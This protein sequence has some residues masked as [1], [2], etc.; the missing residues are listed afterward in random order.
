MEGSIAAIWNTVLFYS[1][2]VF[3]MQTGRPGALLRKQN[4]RKPQFFFLVVAVGE[5]GNKDF[6]VNLFRSVMLPELSFL[7]NMLHHKSRF[8]ADN[9]LMS[10]KCY[11][12]VI[13]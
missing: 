11:H 1:L 6:L 12:C 7:T 13:L 2:L 4:K 10:Y 3:L 8:F 5:I 9:Q